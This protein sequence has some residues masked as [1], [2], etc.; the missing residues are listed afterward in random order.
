MVERLAVASRR[1]GRFRRL[2][3]TPAAGLLLGHIDSLELLEL[4]SPSPKVIY[5]IGAN[6]GTWTRLAKAIHP[7]ARVDGFEPLAAHHGPFTRDTSG[8]A[9]VHLH[10]TALGAA[11]A[12]LEMNVTDLSD[13]SSFLAMNPAASA[14]LNIKSLRRESVQVARLDDYARERKLPLPDLLKLDVQGYELEVLRGAPECLRHA[15]H[16]LCEVSFHEYYEGQPLFHDIVAF[17]ATHGF[18]LSALSEN[19]PLGAVIGQTD[20]LFSKLK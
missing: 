4:L 7:A 19:T 3:G 10:H 1:R 8:L 12:T 20:A 11:P 18:G 16:V 17:L 15:R 13:A 9:D 6:V 14:E 5:D 2:R